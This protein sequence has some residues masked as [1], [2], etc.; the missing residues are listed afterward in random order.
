MKNLGLCPVCN[1]PIQ[2]Y[3]RIYCSKECSLIGRR[4]KQVGESNPAWVGG[5]YVEPGKGYIL[6]RAYGHHRARKNGYV[7]EHILVMERKIGRQLENN[8]V[9][10]HL[11][12]NPADNRPENLVLYSSNGEHLK[13]CGHHRPKH[14]PCRCGRPSVSRGMCVRCYTY[15]RRTGKQRPPVDYDGRLHPLDAP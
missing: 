3:Q 7:L 14:P 1:Q 13:G 12:G 9:V 15:W 6:V 10:H 2:K 4:G 5:K 8:E 11:N